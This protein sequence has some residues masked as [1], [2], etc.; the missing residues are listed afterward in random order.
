MRNT[1]LLFC[2]PLFLLLLTTLNSSC[3]AQ[4]GRRGRD[5]LPSGEWTLIQSAEGDATLET[6]AADGR[7]GGDR[8]A[9]KITVHRSAEPFYR[10]G[11]GKSIAPAVPSES[12]IRLRFRARSATESRVRAI[13]EKAEPPYNGIVEVNVA[14][15]KDWKEY[16]ALGTSPGYGE[17]GLHVRFQFG[18]APG[19]LE[20][21]GIQVEN[22]GPDP[23]IGAARAALTPTAI[24]ERIRR[25][26][27]TNL[28]VR[29]RERGG[30]PARNVRVSVEQTRHA[31]LFGCNIFALEPSGNDP[32]QKAYQERFTE[33]LNFATLP[34]YWGAYEPERGRPQH[35]RVEAMARWCIE[36][37]L[38]T[39]GHPLIWH[40][41]YPGWAP[42]QAD[43]AV[44]L[45][46]G[47]VMEIIPRFKDLITIWDVFNEANNAAEHPQ[48]G[49]GDWV[50]RD[51]VAGAVGTALQWA[52]EAS[53]G[54]KNVTLIYNDF[55]TGPANVALLTE[56]QKRRR[57]PDAI[58]IQSHMHSG[59]WPPEQVWRT[60]ERFSHF[61]K[62]V[63]F[64]ELTVLSGP[65]RNSINYQ[66]PPATDWLTTPEEEAK[67]ADYLERFY[68][69]LFSHPNVHAITYWD[70][71]DRG[72]WL[73][74]P[75]GLL[76]RD[77][78]PKPAYDRLRRLIRET[79]WT[80]ADAST[81]DR[82]EHMLRAFYGEHRITAM[83]EQG[84]T[85]TATVSLPMG[86]SPKTVTLTLP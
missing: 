82:G 75:A 83:D 47:R 16:T 36:H 57:L 40:E 24:Q 1:C 77:M 76:R 31:F 52:R 17:N 30:R 38:T 48:T 21:A 51:G 72:A 15:T 67:Q 27:M 26:R 14:L 25:H 69:I 78:T 7:A 59:T 68:T 22:L 4:D 64:T 61:G 50:K 13:V 39:K 12:L 84:R 28:T 62:P 18:H 6:M 53:R 8:N 3:H 20:F 66:G 70:F 45:L 2:L 33:L 32:A 10:I 49:T 71:S 41:V 44:P 55:N 19:V 23:E 46:R 56:L 58:G 74:A 79:W 54:A 43:E 85:V 11:I 86:S 73:G 65:P 35:E 63:H 5:L 42:K 34:F 37:G 29:V 80:R 81:S 60:A 9:L